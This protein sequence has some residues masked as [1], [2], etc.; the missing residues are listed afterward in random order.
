MPITN[1]D[2]FMVLFSYRVLVGLLLSSLQ[3]L[4][5]QYPSDN[6]I[7]AFNVFKIFNEL[8]ESTKIILCNSCAS[9]H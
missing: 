9:E 8:S 4:C 1:C 6:V 2:L 3:N 7:L 5:N